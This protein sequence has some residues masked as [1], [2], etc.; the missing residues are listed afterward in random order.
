MSIHKYLTSAFPLG[1]VI[2]IY[3]YDPTYRVFNKKF[4]EYIINYKINKK[5]RNYF[6]E[7]LEEGN[8]WTTPFGTF[9][10]Y[11]NDIGNT[12]TW[13][14][15]NYNILFNRFDNYVLFAIVPI[16]IH[17][18]YDEYDECD[19][20]ERYERYDGYICSYGDLNNIPNEITNKYKLPVYIFNGVIDNN[21]LMLYIK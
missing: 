13:L 12:N 9:A 5:I 1:I 10:K 2:L 7:L 15:V 6:D 8:L 20:Y 17:N 11:N 16:H 21:A 14:N 3:E 18:T 4:N 19:R